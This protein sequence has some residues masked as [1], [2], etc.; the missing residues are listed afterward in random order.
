MKGWVQYA[1]MLFVGLHCDPVFRLW[2]SVF[3]QRGIGYQR[4][5]RNSIPQ[6]PGQIY[7]AWCQNNEHKI[8]T[9]LKRTNPKL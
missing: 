7:N 5:Q 4:I 3:W 2:V 1:P 8:I 6:Y 9:G